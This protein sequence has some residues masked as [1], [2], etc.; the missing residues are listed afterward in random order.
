MVAVLKLDN[1]ALGLAVRMATMVPELCVVCLTI[2]CLSVT[3]NVVYQSTCPSYYP[4]T[5]LNITFTP[6]IMCVLFRN[7]IP[8]CARAHYSAHFRFVPATRLLAGVCLFLNSRLLF[9]ICCDFELLDFFEF[10]FGLC[11]KL[12]LFTIMYRP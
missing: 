5:F 10:L 7:L 2:G 9:S 3:A 1:L 4:V 11:R 12:G 6:I 8:Y